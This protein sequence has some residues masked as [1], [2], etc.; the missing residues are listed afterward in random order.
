MIWRYG[1]SD[2]TDLDNEIATGPSDPARQ[3]TSADRMAA[4]AD[5]IRLAISV[6][7]CALVGVG[8]GLYWLPLGFALPG[9]MLFAIAVIGGLRAGR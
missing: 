9:A 3:M 2:V 5:L 1:R 4:V 6:V 8:A 7:G